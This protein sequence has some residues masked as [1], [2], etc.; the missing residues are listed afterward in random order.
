MTF[1]AQLEDL[2][3]T[4]KQTRARLLAPLDF[5]QYQIPRDPEIFVD[6]VLHYVMDQWAED[7]RGQG[8]VLEHDEAWKDPVNHYPMYLL[9]MAGGEHMRIHFTGEYP[10]VLYASFSK[11]TRDPKQ[12]SDAKQL[13]VELPI[14]TDPNILLHSLLDGLKKFR[15]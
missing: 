11:G 15:S 4:L 10:R 3:A 13:Q 5:T 9:R 8:H 2:T 1:T 12:F 7:L 14:T 6:D